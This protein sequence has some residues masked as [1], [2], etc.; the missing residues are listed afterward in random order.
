MK[1]LKQHRIRHIGGIKSIF[2]RTQYY[3]SMM[4]FLQMTAV[5]YTVV[6]KLRYPWMT[7]Y[8]YLA[9]LV[10]V[11]FIAGLFEFK[12]MLP[13]EQAF[14]NWQWW[15]HGNPIR[16]ILDDLKKELKELREEVRELKEK[17]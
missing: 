3:L 17:R 9:G 14:S 12:V 11:I 7:W 16:P 8:H 13:S 10:V 1:I 4:S 5:T 15:E 2:A 6:V